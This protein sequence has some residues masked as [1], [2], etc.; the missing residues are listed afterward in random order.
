MILYSV[1]KRKGM[2]RLF[3][4]VPLSA[5]VHA[6][7]SNQLNLLAFIEETCKRIDAFE[8]HIH[9]LLPE[10]GWRTR[11]I[12]EAKALQERFPDPSTRPALYGIPLGV[13]DLFN[14]DGF[15]THAGSQ[16]PANVFAG[17]EATCV[18]ALR[19]A[20]AI[21]LGKTVSTE[22][23]WF[24]PGPT[25]NPHDLAHTPGGSSSGSAAA[26]AAGF[27]PLALGTQ[28]IGSVIRPAA[29]C[30]VVGF[31]PSY[32]RISTGGMVFCSPSLDTIGFITAD[33][34]GV[35]LVAPLLCRNWQA[36]KA[37]ALPVLGVP[38]G[39]YLAQASPEGLAAFEKQLSILEKAGYTVRRIKAM[40]DIDTIN[41]RD[42]QLVFAEMTQVHATWFSE[43]QTLYRP[44]TVAAIREGQQV[45]PEALATAR[46]G[47]A[48]V[49][50]KL[51]VLMSQNAI[52]LWVAPAAPG[53]APEGIETTGN[54]AMNLPWTYA[55]LPTISLPAGRAENGL[56]LGLQC[57]ADFM[58]D[59]QLVA[60]AEK[61]ASVLHTMG[62]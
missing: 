19:S 33:V 3:L 52:D 6:L 58:A 45:D 23:A 38:D 16:L 48:L 5:T 55:G 39:P 30:G 29:F 62:N 4:P 27:C 21:I 13:K 59:E 53:P 41:Q 42:R 18:N 12:G 47:R 50:A 60:W 35:A 54:P 24:E 44:R 56:P 8:P 34:T 31:K 51:Q 20:G 17:P 36:A 32:G 28:T 2:T 37:Q 11:L 25:R 22:F 57:V 46:T 26:V 9:A 49:R 10:P 61:L 43:Y 7:R 14:V 15:P 40:S 1:T